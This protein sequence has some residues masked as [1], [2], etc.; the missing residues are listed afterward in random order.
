MS[1]LYIIIGYNHQECI[2]EWDGMFL[3]FFKKTKEVVL[4]ICH[5]SYIL[6][7]ITNLSR[8][9]IT[10]LIFLSSLYVFFINTGKLKEV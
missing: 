5:C 2:S 4:Q 7:E 6:S 8:V 1:F 3:S 9:I 10:F